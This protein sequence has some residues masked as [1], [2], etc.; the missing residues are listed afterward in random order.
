MASRLTR[1]ARVLAHS[2]QVINWKQYL[3]IP[4]VPRLSA[5]AQDLILRLCC[6]PEARLGR[7]GATEIKS[8]PFFAGVA[9]STLRQTQA[10]YLPTVRFPTDTS[11]FDPV[12]EAL[13]ALSDPDEEQRSAT[14]NA[15]AAHEQQK[16]GTRCDTVDEC[17][18]EQTEGAAGTA[19][20]SAAAPGGASKKAPKHS[21]KSHNKKHKDTSQQPQRIPDAAPPAASIQDGTCGTL[22]MPPV[23]EFTFRRFFDDSPAG[24]SVYI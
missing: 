1:S 9:F 21:N 17:D 10:A 4:P 6:G 11:N 18:E 12:D 8:Q 14:A 20:S 15:A 22:Q 23:L 24:P 13:A 19:A 16:R 2:S 7:K 3:R 5:P